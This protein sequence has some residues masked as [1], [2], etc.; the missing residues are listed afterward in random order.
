MICF[1][2]IRPNV[3]LCVAQDKVPDENPV[4][5]HQ[6]SMSKMQ[7]QEKKLRTAKEERLT[8]KYN[9]YRYFKLMISDYFSL[10]HEYVFEQIFYRKLLYTLVYS[11]TILR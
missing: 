11:A 7:G 3:S 9:N 1:S 2:C 8:G 6:G 4:L 10:V 5:E